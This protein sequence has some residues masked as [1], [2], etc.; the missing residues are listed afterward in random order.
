[1]LKFS[2][3]IADKWKEITNNDKYYSSIIDLYANYAKI[4]MQKIREI[5]FKEKEN[6]KRKIKQLENYMAGLGR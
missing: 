3:E 5:N 1:M 2:K 6:V 4:E